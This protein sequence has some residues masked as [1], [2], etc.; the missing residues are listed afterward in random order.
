MQDENGRDVSRTGTGSS[1]GGGLPAVAVA[2]WVVPAM[3][4]HLVTN[5][6]SLGFG[7]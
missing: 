6:S 5:I 7:H 2:V 1:H 4:Q 3:Y